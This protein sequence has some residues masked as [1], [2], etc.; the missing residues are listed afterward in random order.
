MDIPS[1]TSGNPGGG[2]DSGVAAN[3]GSSSSSSLTTS[4]ALQL[5]L[6]KQR[7]Q[8]LGATVQSQGEVVKAQEKS[9]SLLT[10]TLIWLG[11]LLAVLI[12]AWLVRWLNVRRKYALLLEF[13]KQVD[14]LWGAPMSPG[15][16]IWCANYPNFSTI[17]SSKLL[18][19]NFPTAVALAFYSQPYSNLFNLSDIE[20]GAYYLNEMYVWA[21]QHASASA[22]EIICSSLG[23]DIGA[24]DCFEECGIY[25]SITNGDV[26]VSSLNG[27]TQGIFLAR[28]SFILSSSSFR[29]SFNL[30]SFFST[31]SIF[32][33]EAVGGGIAIGAASVYFGVAGLFALVFAGIH[34]GVKSAEK[35]ELDQFCADPQAYSCRSDTGLQC[36]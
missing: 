29:I 10:K 24:T 36:L 5:L 15:K 30:L 1:A 33:P 16:L 34:V 18:N 8:A 31:F 28:Y 35:K 12:T 13:L 7:N 27:I 6:T 21:D 9:L 20:G 17:L 25:Y 4:Q 14:S 22:Q 32:V 2:L 3:S 19:R 26:A 11:S 23:S